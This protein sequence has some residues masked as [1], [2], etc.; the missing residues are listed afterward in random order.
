M[1]PIKSLICPF[2]VL[3]TNSLLHITASQ[4]LDLNKLYSWHF[5]LDGQAYGV[6]L[7]GEQQPCFY[8]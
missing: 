7:D 4:E 2:F 1:H 6:E 3:L 8:G 5:T